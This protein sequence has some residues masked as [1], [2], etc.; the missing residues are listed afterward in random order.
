MILFGIEFSVAQLVLLAANGLL[1]LLCIAI[2]RKLGNQMPKEAAQAPA[3]APAAKQQ[4]SAAA[5]EE[6]ELIAV[7][8]AA[9]A[10]MMG[11][12]AKDVKVTSYQ[13]IKSG[14]ATANT[15]VYAGR[16]AW[17]KAGRAAQINRYI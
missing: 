4:A 16:S 14:K 9:V 15:R 2:L 7:I 8:T 17:S 3:A 13:E 10:A 1:I 12:D 6:E 5:Q 11:K